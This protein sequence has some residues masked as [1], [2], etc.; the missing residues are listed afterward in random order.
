MDEGLAVEPHVAA[1]QA[2]GAKAIKVLDV[3]IDAGRFLVSTDDAYVQADNT[4][5]APKV[6]GCRSRATRPRWTRQSAR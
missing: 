1:L 3:V 4:T 2:L 6:S 5:I